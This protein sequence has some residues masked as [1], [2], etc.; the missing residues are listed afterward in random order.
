MN[1]LPPDKRNDDQPTPDD[2]NPPNLGDAKVP[3]PEDVQD[4]AT[5]ATPRRNSK[6]V[7]TLESVEEEKRKMRAQGLDLF[8]FPLGPADMWEEEEA[9]P[10]RR[11]VLEPFLKGEL[12]LLTDA[13]VSFLVRYYPNTWGE[14]A[15]DLFKEI[16]DKEDR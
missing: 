12:D 1:R 2:E 3:K 4:N 14:A 8:G 15:D 11:E 5:D 13:L 9:P 16:C 7:V 10:V 6:I